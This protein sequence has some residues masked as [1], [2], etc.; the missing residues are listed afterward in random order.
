MS[1]HSRRD[2]R[3]PTT[4]PALHLPRLSLR[5]LLPLRELPR[6]ARLRRR[7]VLLRVL[8]LP[9][10]RSALTRLPV[11]RLRSALPRL[12][13]LGSALS[14]L[15][16]LVRLCRWVLRLTLGL[17]RGRAVLRELLRVLARL[18][19]VRRVLLAGRRRSGHKVSC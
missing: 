10:L 5:H 13:V 8:L 16:V 18:L 6:L 11:L 4:E 19:R 17:A 2:C 15:A 7:I 9:V 14:G 12:S 1:A 3:H